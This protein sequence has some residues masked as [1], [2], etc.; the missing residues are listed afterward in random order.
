[1]RPRLARPDLRG[2]LPLARADPR[3]LPGRSLLWPLRGG[4]DQPEV[5]AR[6]R[7]ARALG[8]RLEHRGGDDRLRAESADLLRAVVD[9]TDRG[10]VGVRATRRRE[11]CLRDRL[12]GHRLRSLAREDR[13]GNPRPRRPRQGRGRQPCGVARTPRGG[14]MA[15]ESPIAASGTISLGSFT[16]HRLGYG[17]MRLSGPDAWGPPPDEAE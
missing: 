8:T 7:P 6:A 4:G 17:A 9:R 5:P 15:A 11:A 12:A 10:Q 1:R 2:V 3:Q 14:V 16:V 13:A